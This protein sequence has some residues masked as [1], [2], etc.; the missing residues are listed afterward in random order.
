MVEGLYQELK[1]GLQEDKIYLR[2]NE[3][4]NNKCIFTK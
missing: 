2:L 4:L 3:F 1:P